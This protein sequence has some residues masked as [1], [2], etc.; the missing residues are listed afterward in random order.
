MF[1]E[2]TKDLDSKDSI[3]MYLECDLSRWNLH[4]RAQV[5]NPIGSDINHLFGTKRVFTYVHSFFES[6]VIVVRTAKLRPDGI[7]TMDPPSSD[8]V[9]YNHKG[10]FEGI[11]QKL[12]TIATYAMVFRALGGLA[13]SKVLIGQGDNQIFSLLFPRDTTISEGAQSLRDSE[14]AGK[15]LERGCAEVGQDL[16]YEECQESRSV[17]TYSKDV[18]INGAQF[19]LSCKFLSK[20][21]AQTNESLPSLSAELN[22]IWASAQAAAEA[23]HRPLSVYPIA[24]YLYT[25]E[26]IQRARETHPEWDRVSPQSKARLADLSLPMALKIIWWPSR[27]GGLTTAC[28]FDFINRG[29]ADPLS[30]QV[31]A[32]HLGASVSSYVAPLMVAYVSRSM[33]E[34][35][36]DAEHLLIDPFAIPLEPIRTCS[37]I[38]QARVHDFV[39]VE[40]KNPDLKALVSEETQEYKS[41]LIATLLSARPLYPTLL[42]EILDDSAIGEAA[43]LD[44][45]FTATH[46][47]QQASR[48]A[49][50]DATTEIVLGSGEELLQLLRTPLSSTALADPLPYWQ[51]SCRRAKE[52]KEV[53]GPVSRTRFGS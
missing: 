32:L 45:M 35:P 26:L 1:F 52:P 16:K 25:R 50:F 19:F 51:S 49:G 7:E 33:C 4:W 9:W 5:V 13:C 21:E 10:G 28:L 22:A 12:W 14:L 17:I 34:D 39:E 8:L 27:L 3:H 36:T 37:G 6:S 41:A 29:G 44:K 31:A 24:S 20:L 15:M 53:M 47:L 43:K 2:L 48:A 18:W 38:V 40:A 46:T 42:R 30:S 11:A 23:N